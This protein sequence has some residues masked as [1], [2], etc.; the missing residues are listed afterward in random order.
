MPSSNSKAD[1]IVNLKGLIDAGDRS[2]ELQQGIEVE[3]QAVAQAVTEIESL[4]GRQEELTGLRQEVT[5]QL[6]AAIGRGKEAGIR[7]RSMVRAKI[8]PHNER[9]AQFKMAPIRRRPRKPQVVV[10]VKSPDG[11]SLGTETGTSVPPP[12][13]PVV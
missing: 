1:V 10:V 7:Y 4:K 6:K 8:G 3:R 5:Q 2:P 13:K 11:E 9:L 12:A